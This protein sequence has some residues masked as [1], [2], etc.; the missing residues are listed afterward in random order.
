L[1]I[2]DISF[3][4]DL[5]EKET[6]FRVPEKIRNRIEYLPIKKVEEHFGQKFESISKIGDPE[7]LRYIALNPEIFESV[8]VDALHK[9]SAQ[10][11]F[12]KLANAELTTPLRLLSIAFL[13]DQATIEDLAFHNQDTKVREAAV[14]NL[15]SQDL[16]L[17]IANNDHEATVQ[18]AAVKRIDNQSTLFGI[19][20]NHQVY[21]I[22][23]VA[24]NQISFRS[25]LSKLVAKS[26][27]PLIHIAAER[28]L[29]NLPDSEQD[30]WGG[31]FDYPEQD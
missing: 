18:E 9:I 31:V 11:V 21:S 16:L 17:T 28:R 27:H 22:K 5:L 3:L 24:V 4:I 8:R 19:A 23:M 26:E 30:V 12:K 1:G 25:L 29:S 10:K 7:V 6:D 14:R 20:M 13:K 15:E 2:H